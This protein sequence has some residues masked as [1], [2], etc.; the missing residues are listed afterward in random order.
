MSNPQIDWLQILNNVN[1]DRKKKRLATF[2]NLKEML[3]CLYHQEETMIVRNMAER[4]RYESSPSSTAV[5]HK[6]Y[7]LGIEMKQLGHSSKRKKPLKSLRP[8]EYGFDTEKGLLRH[9]RLEKD[10]SCREMVKCLANM[11]IKVSV[12]LL[13]R[14]MKLYDIKLDAKKLRKKRVDNLKKARDARGSK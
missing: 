10:L 14:R 11:G 7:D 5:L 12:E 6:M 3:T 1:K 8:E 4:F 2:G 9:W 13:Y